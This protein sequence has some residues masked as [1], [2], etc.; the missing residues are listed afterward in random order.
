MYPAGEP[1]REVVPPYVRQVTV[2][3]PYEEPAPDTGGRDQVI[4]LPPPK[5]DDPTWRRSRRRSGGLPWWAMIPIVLLAAFGLYQAGQR[6]W[7][8]QGEQAARDR[9]EAS[10]MEAASA[11]RTEATRRFRR[12]AD[13][14]QSAVERYDVRRTDF[15]RNRIECAALAEGYRRVD[16]QFVSL[17]VLV[18]ERGDRLGAGT[19]DRYEELTGRVGQVNRH[20]DGTGCRTSG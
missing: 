17:S 15:E 18:R 9:S 12:M 6:W 1:R 4:V 5:D 16:R 19:R 2:I 3:D 8:D 7:F 14:L 11:E 13:S 10:G 20:F